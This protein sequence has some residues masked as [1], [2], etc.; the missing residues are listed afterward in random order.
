M[1]VVHAIFVDSH[2]ALKIIYIYI[3]VDDI[4]FATAFCGGATGED[5]T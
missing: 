4:S 5:D 3:Y 1:G 2:D